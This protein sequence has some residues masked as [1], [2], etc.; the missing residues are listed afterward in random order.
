MHKQ[1]KGST[2]RERDIYIKKGQKR[3]FEGMKT[4]E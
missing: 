4:E 1:G 2:E 3:T